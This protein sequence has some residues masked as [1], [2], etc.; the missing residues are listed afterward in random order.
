MR[1][2]FN[3]TVEDRSLRRYGVN[4]ACAYRLTGRIQRILC[5]GNIV[6]AGVT[7]F[8]GQVREALFYQ[9]GGVDEDVLDGYTEVDA[10]IIAEA[11]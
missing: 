6:F 7:L 1:V 9:H 4:I 8:Y 10:G 5:D 2:P 3:G 11:A